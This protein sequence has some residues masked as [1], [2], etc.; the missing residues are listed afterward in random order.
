MLIIEPNEYPTITHSFSVGDEVIDVLTGVGG[1]ITHIDVYILSVKFV[2]G[3]HYCYAHSLIL[4]GAMDILEWRAAIS[5]TTV[6]KQWYAHDKT[7]I[8]PK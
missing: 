5:H 1:N 2:D 6:F 7:K 4:I 3:S 8:K